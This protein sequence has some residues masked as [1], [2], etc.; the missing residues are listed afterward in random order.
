[1]TKPPF[2]VSRV[3][4]LSTAHVSQ[5]TMD[6]LLAGPTENAFGTVAAY[7]EGVFLSLT[8]IRI[9]DDLPEDLAALCRWVRRRRYGWIRLDCD[10]DTVDDLPVH[11]W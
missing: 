2:W 3:P 10:G 11:D 8:T 7:P 9:P 5:E 4:V 1:M 6:M